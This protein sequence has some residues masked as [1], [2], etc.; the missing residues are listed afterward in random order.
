MNTIACKTL[1]LRN[2]IINLMQLVKYY[3]KL[4]VKAIE[5]KVID[6]KAYI[7]DVYRKQKK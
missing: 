1:Y 5:D 6:I 2:V 4:D 7:V 3:S